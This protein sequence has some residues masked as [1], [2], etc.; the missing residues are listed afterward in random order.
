[1]HE[2]RVQNRSYRPWK[3]QISWNIV[4]FLTKK[5]A[6][7]CSLRADCLICFKDIILISY[8]SSEQVSD[9][10]LLIWLQWENKQKVAAL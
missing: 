5:Q 8:A 2:L 6:V 3:V 4:L 9:A 10:F 7:V 1:M